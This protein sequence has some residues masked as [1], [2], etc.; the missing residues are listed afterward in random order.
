MSTASRPNPY[1]GHTHNTPRPDASH[2][3]FQSL[4]PSVLL[5]AQTLWDAAEKV[6]AQ[7]EI[8]KGLPAGMSFASF[9]PMS[10]AADQEE[11][12]SKAVENRLRVAFL[13]SRKGA[14]IAEWNEQRAAITAGYL[15]KTAA[16][17]DLPT[18]RVDRGY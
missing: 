6:R 4:R 9:D 3:R 14:T 12:I 17:E 10:R 7:A 16:Q 8:D 15:E 11:P 18:P 2:T 1:I 13:S 5:L